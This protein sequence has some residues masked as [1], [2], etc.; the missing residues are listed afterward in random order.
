[1]RIGIDARFITRHPRRGIGNYSLHVV[2]ALVKLCPDAEFFLYISIPDSEGVLPEACNVTVRRLNMPAY[3]LWEQVTLPAAAREDRLDILHCLGNTA[4]VFMPK[5]TRLV[6]TL[7]DVMFLQSGEFVPKPTN[8][9][10]ALGR[11]Y[12]RMVAPRCAR[13]ADHVITVSEFSRQDILQLIPGLDPARVH[14]THQS[15]DP[16]FKQLRSAAS[17]ATAARG[18]ST[19]PYIFTLG[20]DDPR[21]NTLRLVQAYLSLLKEHAIDHDLV[22]SG[23]ANWEQSESYQLVKGAGATERVKFRGFITLEEL[24]ALYRDAA[25]FVYPSLYEGF[26][27]PV[28]EGFSSGCPVIA[29]NV[30]SIPEVGGDAVLYVDPLS[31][32][33][34]RSAVL[35]VIQD[36][37][38]RESLSRSGY[39]RAQQFTWEEAAR[40]TLAIYEACLANPIAA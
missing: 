27:I 12:R 1:M 4:P 40:K 15:C 23:Y 2:A 30:T 18:E 17:E 26:G 8:R 39:A 7:H 9:Y 31:V 38:L 16:A 13:V 25:L 34:I 22:I 36:R 20:A 5:S 14:V 28:L 11:H 37:E 32:D 29:S 10:Q 35:R 21:K 6:L 24:V 19:R 33:D 3:P